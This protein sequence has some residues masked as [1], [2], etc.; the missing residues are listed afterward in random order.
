M[1]KLLL[2]LFAL[3]INFL[4]TN[5][6]EY[7]ST[8]S[9]S[10]FG[11]VINWP[12]GDSY[13]GGLIN[14]IMEGKGTYTWANGSKYVGQW[15]NGKRHGFGTEYY[16]GQGKYI[17]NWI[18]GIAEGYGVLYF[19]GNTYVGEWKNFQFNGKGLYDYFNGD[20][21]KGTF[22]NGE[23]EGN[24]ILVTSDG[25]IYTGTWKQD[26]L[27]GYCKVTHP[28][29]KKETQYWENGTMVSKKK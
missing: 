29:G 27:H 9:I 20:R 10:V 23:R 21:F 3:F 6:Q 1:K 12:N 4:I 28:D 18:N 7:E 16:P 22:V 11:D 17:G 5:A 13:E 24:G 25:Y 8:D 14:G 19:D 15:R 2:V 26:K